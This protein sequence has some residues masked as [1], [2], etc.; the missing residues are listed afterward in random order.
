MS[1]GK[2]VLFVILIFAVVVSGCTQANAPPADDNQDDTN[3]QIEPQ[4]EQP[5]EEPSS[6]IGNETDVGPTAP[7]PPAPAA[8]EPES[9]P[10]ALP[11]EPIAEAPAEQPSGDENG[12]A[13]NVKEFDVTAKSWEF[14]PSTITVN[15]GDTVKLHITSIDVE[16]GFRL[17]EFKV[18]EKL[19]K[20]ETVN[21]EFVA[22]KAGSFTF[23]CNVY[24]GEGHSGMRGTLVVNE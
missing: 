24:C 1:Y 22:D 4:P 20:G 15:K 6:D 2:A 17:A 7:L 9:T 5:S 8:E 12:S 3:A 16:H 11:I 14:V 13:A 18:N 19:K 23:F 10:P 21:V